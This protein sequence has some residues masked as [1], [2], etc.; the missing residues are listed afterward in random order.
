VITPDIALLLRSLRHR[1]RKRGPAGRAGDEAVVGANARQWLRFK[2]V[3]SMAGIK[4]PRPAG[5][6]LELVVST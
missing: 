4:E 3:I 2:A 5:R 1:K 6:Q